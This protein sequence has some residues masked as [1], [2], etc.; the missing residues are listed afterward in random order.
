MNHDKNWICNLYVRIV[1][2]PLYGTASTNGND[3]FYTSYSTAQ[4]TLDDSMT[5]EIF[6][7]SNV[8]EEIAFTINLFRQM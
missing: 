4:A 7:G 2:Q 3:I 5:F 8:S 6:D 1:D